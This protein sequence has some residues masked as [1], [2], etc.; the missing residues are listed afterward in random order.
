MVKLHDEIMKLRDDVRTKDD[1]L[2]DLSQKIIEKAEKNQLLT[3]KLAE[4]KNHQLT[5]HYLNQ[6]YLVQKATKKGPVD[7]LVSYFYFTS[8]SSDSFLTKQKNIISSWK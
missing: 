4:M 6:S 7:L 1:A 2:R 8:F 5:T 3:E